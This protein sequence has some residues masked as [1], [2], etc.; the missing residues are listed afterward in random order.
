MTEPDQ[1]LSDKQSIV[2]KTEP[3]VNQASDKQMSCDDKLLLLLPKVM[4]SKAERLLC[5]FFSKEK[6]T[7]IPA[8]KC[9]LKVKL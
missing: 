4:R 6:L 5:L 7:G 8:A 2:H 3:H 1:K 9:A